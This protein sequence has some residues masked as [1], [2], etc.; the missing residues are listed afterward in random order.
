[1]NENKSPRTIRRENAYV[2]LNNYLEKDYIFIDYF[3]DLVNFFDSSVYEILSKENFFEEFKQKEIQKAVK[4]LIKDY[5]EEIWLLKTKSEYICAWM[6]KEDEMEYFQSVMQDQH[7][8]ERFKCFS[9]DEFK[10][11]DKLM[12]KNRLTLEKA[13]KTFGVYEEVDDE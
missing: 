11:A 5:L 10:K 3:I 13:L 4:T 6:K 12:K 2:L 8:I 1:M 9:I 7:L